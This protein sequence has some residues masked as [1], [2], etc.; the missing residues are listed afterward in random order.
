M[1][2][3][4][5]AGVIFLLLSSGKRNTNGGDGGGGGGDA[6]I[7]PGPIGPVG[8]V[9]H[10]PSEDDVVAMMCSLFNSTHA[11]APPQL[12][13]VD[14]FKAFGF[15][16]NDPAVAGMVDKAF[17]LAQKLY[18]GE[19]VCEGDNE[20]PYSKSA[21]MCAL[22]GQYY[23]AAQWATPQH[24]IDELRQLGFGKSIG[25]TAS[26]TGS[27][28]KAEIKRFQAIARSLGLNGMNSAP[29]SYIDGKLGACTLLS[30]TDANKAR[31]SGVWPYALV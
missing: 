18:S 1:G 10:V 4:V 25:R 9:D 26:I 13:T 20:I 12:L 5:L 30:L 19:V 7:I 21:S 27:A 28:W 23:N 8:P 15:A 2:G 14:T 24:V 16:T 17:Q 29:T 11:V 31:T 22:T 3:W 6:D